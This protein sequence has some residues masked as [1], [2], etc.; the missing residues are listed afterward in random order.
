MGLRTERK[1]VMF[2]GIATV[3]RQCKDGCSQGES[4]SSVYL[5]G[6]GTIPSTRPGVK[7]LFFTSILVCLSI[8][9]GHNP[10]QT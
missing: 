3:N 7:L 4:V 5:C 9:Y 2:Y 6:S 8:K 10:L 1:D